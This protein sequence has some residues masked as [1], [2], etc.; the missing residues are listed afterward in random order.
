MI[1]PSDMVEPGVIFGSGVKIWTNTHIRANAFIGDNVAVGE[2]FYT[3]SGV[4]IGGNSKIQNG[5]MVYKPEKIG[6]GVFIGRDSYLTNAKITRS[7]TTESDLK[8]PNDWS[9][10]AV[11]VKNG[12]SIGAGA[13]CV[14]PIEISDWAMVGAGSGSVVIKNVKA[15]S[16]YV[17]N[18]AKYTGSVNK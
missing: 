13:I 8:K 11:I 16:L 10:S 18:P 1:V 2:S 4:E 5:E 12:A 7:V 15:Y 14:A 3:G 6:E 17:G 9:P